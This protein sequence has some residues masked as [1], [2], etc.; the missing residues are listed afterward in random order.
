M[1]QGGRKKRSERSHLLVNKK[2]TGAKRGT[3]KKMRERDR[4][5]RGKSEGGINTERWSRVQ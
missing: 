4:E 1:T 3:G 2:G 5:R